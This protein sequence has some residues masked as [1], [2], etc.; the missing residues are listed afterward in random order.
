MSYQQFERAVLVPIADHRP[1]P[2]AAR[3]HRLA[4][5]HRHPCITPPG[6]QS[7][8]LADVIEED[9]LIPIVVKIS[10]DHRPHPAGG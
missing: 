7:I 4:D 3:L 5:I 8:R 9:L 2:Q 10:S 1:G 6:K